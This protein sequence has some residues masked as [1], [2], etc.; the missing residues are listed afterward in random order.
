MDNE[1]W[2]KRQTATP[3]ARRLYEE[4]R[5]ILWAT[6]AIAETIEEQGRTRADVA[7]ALGTSRPNVTQLL[8]GSRNMT[9]RTLAAL[10]HA[11]GMRA[12]LKLEP[13]PRL[14]H[15][16]EVTALDRLQD[17]ARWRR[18]ESESVVDEFIAER[19]A[20]RHHGGARKAP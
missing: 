12:D 2:V 16:P 15:E 19:R 11:C 5:L 1:T 17:Y 14:A 9:L 4:E 13:L 18:Q 10:A 3:E 20:L 8:N 7:K 6:E